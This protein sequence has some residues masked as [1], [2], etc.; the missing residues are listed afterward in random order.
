MNEPPFEIVNC[1]CVTLD[2]GESTMS[3]IF[4]REALA[5]ARVLL[6]LGKIS[7]RIQGGTPFVDDDFYE[8]PGARPRV[9]FKPEPQPEIK[10]APKPCKRR[11]I[12]L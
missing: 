3:D 8:M 10:M 4:S 9:E 1:R 6:E 7:Y 5:R 11:P 12:R 2:A